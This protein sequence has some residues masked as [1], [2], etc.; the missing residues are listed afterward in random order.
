[1]SDVIPSAAKPRKSDKRR[2]AFLCVGDLILTI[3]YYDS[4]A[5]R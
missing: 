5:V 2:F 3:V 4:A 1:V